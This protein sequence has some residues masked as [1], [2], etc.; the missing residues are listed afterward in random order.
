[1]QLTYTI[2]IQEYKNMVL[3]HPEKEIVIIKKVPIFCI[4]K[5]KIET[6]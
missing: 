3:I 2:G 4:C 5:F 6:L 1:M